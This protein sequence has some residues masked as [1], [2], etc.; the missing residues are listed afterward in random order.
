[1]NKTATLRNITFPRGLQPVSRHA[2]AIIITGQ[3]FM[4][5]RL[6][7]FTDDFPLN[8]YAAS[9]HNR[10]K[11]AAAALI[12]I[13][14]S[15]LSRIS[16]DS[17]VGLMLPTIE[18][19]AFYHAETNRSMTFRWYRRCLQMCGSPLKRMTRLPDGTHNETWQCVGYYD[20]IN[21]FLHEVSSIS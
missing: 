18:I 9:P 12:L 11:V 17:W 6:C 10:L 21:K 7:S 13:N 2:T 1:M 5:K 14:L 4:R 3:T 20:A 8:G 19:W 16:V 15:R